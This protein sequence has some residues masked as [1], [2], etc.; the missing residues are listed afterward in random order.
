LQSPHAA[1]LEGCIKGAIGSI[2]SMGSIGA[3]GAVGESLSPALLKA[4]RLV[5]ALD[6]KANSVAA[7]VRKSG[8]EDS[9]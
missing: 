8:R 4:K 9:I 5:T 2:G 7:V 1:T 6:E 3:M